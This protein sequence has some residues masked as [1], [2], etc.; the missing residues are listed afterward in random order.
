MV[1]ILSKNEGYMS[2]FI[3]RIGQKYGEWTILERA[4]NRR[5]LTM[6][7]CECKCGTKKIIR[8][9]EIA[10]NHARKDCGCSRSWIGKRFGKLKII[11]NIDKKTNHYTRFNCICDCGN[12]RIVRGDV[13]YQSLRRKFI[14]SCGCIKTKKGTE[15]GITKVI[16]GYQKVAKKY[17]REFLLSKDDFLEICSKNCFYCGSIPSNSMV[18]RDK[19]NG[20]RIFKYNGIDRIDNDKGYVKENCVPCCKI[21]N[22]MKRELS[23]NEWF[24]QMKKI[25]G[26]QSQFNQTI[27]A[28]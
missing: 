26:H 8:A 10:I 24:S 15:R 17:N 12:E 7:L 14:I 20:N 11:E 27:P 16:S 13:L 22:L 21:C 5:S 9:T 28:G 19:T 6:W 2:D 4:P 23:I 1:I 3:D 18:L 25:L